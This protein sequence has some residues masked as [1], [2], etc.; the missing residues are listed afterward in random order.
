MEELVE[1]LVSERIQEILNSHAESTEGKKTESFDRMGNVLDSLEPDIRT[2]VEQ[3]M[4]EFVSLGAETEERL[5]VTGIEDG[6]RIAKWF[7]KK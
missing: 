7:F 1:L 4:N 3:V 5:Y 2:A 6:I